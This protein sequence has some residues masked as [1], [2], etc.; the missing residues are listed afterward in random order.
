MNRQ[1]MLEGGG[2]LIQQGNVLFIGGAETL[3]YQVK[4]QGKDL[5]RTP[6]LKVQDNMPHNNF[7][8]DRERLA[9]AA[10]M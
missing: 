5:S 10:Q 4:Y 1:Q 6:K 8:Q 9:P 2:T 7:V 3:K